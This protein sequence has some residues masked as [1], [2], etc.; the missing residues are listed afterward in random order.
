V[1]KWKHNVEQAWLGPGD[2]NSGQVFNGKVVGRTR[3]IKTLYILRTRNIDRLEN[4]ATI[5]TQEM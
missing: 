2:G 1:K 3:D 5:S 4:R